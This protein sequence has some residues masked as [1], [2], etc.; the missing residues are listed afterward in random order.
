MKIFPILATMLAAGLAMAEP[1]VPAVQQPV[2]ADV[3]TMTQDARCKQVVVT[4]LINGQPMRMMLDTGATHTVLHEES[5]ESLKDARWID[6]SRMLF[7]GNS[8]QRPRLL[9]AN[10]LAGPAESAEHPFMVMN[11][12]AVRSMMVE[13][14]DGIL[15]MDILRAVPFTFDL[16]KNEFYWGIPQDA[17]LTPLYAEADG[18]GRVIVQGKCGEQTVRMLLDTGSSVTRVVASEWTPGEGAEVGARMGNIDESMG[19]RLMEGKPG[20]L[21]LGA[22]VVA[23]GITPLLCDARDVP[24]LGMDALQGL[25]L[26][27]V[28]S[29]ETPHGIFLIAQ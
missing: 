25:V 22:G 18:T 20:D 17:Q 27:H 11:L 14:I 7:R 9:V 13:K 8:A 28:P 29:E 26:V 10:L 6:T 24:M 2:Q 23:M 5:A 12:G 1:P 3:M 21:E 19:I 15:G 16:R 4:C